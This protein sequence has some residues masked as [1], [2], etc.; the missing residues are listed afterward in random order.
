[1]SYEDHPLVKA[2]RHNDD[3]AEMLGFPLA[4]ESLGLDLKPIAHVADQRALRAVLLIS[5]GKDELEKI[6]K[7]SEE[8]TVEL[9]PAERMYHS[10]LS[11]VLMDGISIGWKAAQYDQ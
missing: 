8:V 11:A 7:Q 5:R 1:M 9:S 2:A 10:Q 4:L 3:M 6:V